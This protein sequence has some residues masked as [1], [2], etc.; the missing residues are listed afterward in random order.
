MASA[1]T[2]R[3]H[4]AGCA[5]LRRYNI[6]LQKDSDIFASLDRA[7]WVKA[8]KLIIAIILATDNQ[9]H[10]KHM[11]ACVLWS[12]HAMLAQRTIADKAHAQCCRCK[13]RAI[14]NRPL[15]AF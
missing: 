7:D 9:Y 3:W 2:M 6:L 15:R 5:A 11:C 1:A 13:A 4:C 14:C 12:K 8:R 10:F